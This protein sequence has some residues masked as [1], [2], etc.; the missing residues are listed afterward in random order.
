MPNSFTIPFEAGENRSKSNIIYYNTT[1]Y[2]RAFHRSSLYSATL[3]GGGAAVAEGNFCR[4][5]CKNCLFEL[6][7]GYPSTG[8]KTVTLAWCSG[9]FSSV[10]VAL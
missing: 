5:G 3:P 2:I 1:T 4:V 8:K 7:R 10:M 6:S 9:V